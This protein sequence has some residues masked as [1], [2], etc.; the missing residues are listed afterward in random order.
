[1]AI[2]LQYFVLRFPIIC[3]M[4]LVQAVA[5]IGGVLSTFALSSSEVLVYDLPMA[6]IR[7]YLVVFNVSLWS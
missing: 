3:S 6:A 4:L 1:M 2:L 5:F 7:F